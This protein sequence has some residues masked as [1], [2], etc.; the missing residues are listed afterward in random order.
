MAYSENKAPI[1]Q[2]AVE[3]EVS[4]EI[5]ATF[6]QNHPKCDMILDKPVIS[7]SPSVCQKNYL[8]E[9]REMTRLSFTRSAPGRSG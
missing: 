7:S 5:P 2:K 9:G 3:G 8:E 1:V 4:S 6:L